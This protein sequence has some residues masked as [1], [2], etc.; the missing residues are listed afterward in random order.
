MQKNVLTPVLRT[1]SPVSDTLIN[2]SSA[3]L[4]GLGLRRPK[5]S[6]LPVAWLAAG[7]AIGGA[8]AYLLTPVDNRERLL[9]LLQRGGGGIGKRLGE[10]VGAQVGAHPVATTKFVE[11][12]RDILKPN[13][14]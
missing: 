8:A 14:S 3:A 7:L 10:L 13:P 9:R 11:K 4:L 6:A 1:L 2:A 5:R 12:A